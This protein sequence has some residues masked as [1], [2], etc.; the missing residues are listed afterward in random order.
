MW[1]LL[2]L[3]LVVWVGLGFCDGGGFFGDGR[4][5]GESVQ[6]CRQE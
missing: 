4:G 6:G 5:E 2:L 3:F 1:V